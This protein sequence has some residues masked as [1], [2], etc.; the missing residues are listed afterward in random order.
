M[1]TATL[2]TQM[3]YTWR[4]TIIKP[5]STEQWQLAVSEDETILH[6]TFV[7]FT[8][9]LMCPSLTSGSSKRLLSS[10]V[11]DFATWH[12]LRGM[13]EPIIS[14]DISARAAR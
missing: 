13:S 11:V 1:R 10:H 9:Y 2:Q 5:V 4:H 7:S 8:S 6:S 3:L 14:P 12:S